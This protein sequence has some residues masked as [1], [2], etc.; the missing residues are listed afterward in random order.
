M[1]DEP[2][3]EFAKEILRKVRQIEIRSNRLVSEALAGSYHSA[4]KG[5]GIDFEE[6]REYQAGDDVRSIDWNVTAKMNVPFVK[7]YR[8]E[9]ELTIVLAVD[10]SASGIF[11][12]VEQ[13]KRERLAELAA[14]LAFSADRNNDK[15]GLI[16]FTDQVDHYLP[17]AKGQKH[18][19]RVL[20][21]ILF[22]KTKGKGTN[23]KASLRFLNRVMKRRSVV[24]LLSD[25]MTP[26]EENTAESREDT[27]F[28]EL[29]TTRR[30]HDLICAHVSDPRE[31]DLP[32]VGLILLEDAE[33]GETLEVN[34][35]DDA[36]RLRFAEHNEN[37][38]DK[39]KQRLLRRGID[40][41]RF[42]TASDYVMG[43]REFFK[44]REKRRRGR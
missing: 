28:K 15:V 26:E 9:R 16:L 19:L 8:E 25:F 23:L 32:A 20:R 5:Q 2:N 27:L 30:R 41:F 18:V 12:S 36:F 39:F 42:S 38:I 33:T 44:L 22:H 14:L 17:P 43:L 7:Q 40:H 11:G 31:T 3:P 35:N 34:T 21:E 29:S 4:F 13:S 1:D 6:V 37:R 10:L 24:F